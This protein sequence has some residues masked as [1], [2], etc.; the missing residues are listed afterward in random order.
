MVQS[1]VE[2]RFP[3]RLGEQLAGG[4]EGDGD[5]PCPFCSCERGTMIHSA[6][7]Y[8]N[9]AAA[10]RM[11][12]EERDVIDGGVIGSSFVLLLLCLTTA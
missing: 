8:Y 10:T 5:G 7:V 4:R 2:G 11:D 6:G 12:E 9:G 1:A 3:R